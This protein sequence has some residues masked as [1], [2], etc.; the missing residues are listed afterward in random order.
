MAKKIN[1]VSNTKGQLLGYSHYCPGCGHDHVFYTTPESQYHCLWTFVNNDFEK[2]TFRASM[3]VNPK[4]DPSYHRCHY[5][6]TDG[7]IQY[8]NDCTHSLKGK[9]IKMKNI[10]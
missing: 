10:E 3:L 1:I 8:L 4:N 5:F 9:T 7:E 2:P 6:I